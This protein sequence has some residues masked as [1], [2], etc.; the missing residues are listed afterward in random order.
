MDEDII[1]KSVDGMRIASHM[2]R[3]MPFHETVGKAFMDLMGWME[4][5][6]IHPDM[7]GNSGLAEYYDDPATTPPDQVKF[8]VGVPVPADTELKTDGEAGIEDVA[9]TE[10]VV[11]RFTGGYTDLTDRYKAVMGY[12]MANGLQVTGAPR[13]LYVKWGEDMPEEEWITE[14]QFPITR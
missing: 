13:E 2:G 6:G 12:V 14:I 7:S 5:N 1:I 11:L 3:G 9:P 4:A 8:K 10:A